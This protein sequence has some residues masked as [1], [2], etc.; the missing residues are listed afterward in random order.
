MTFLRGKQNRL[1]Q[2]SSLSSH[3]NF[4][5]FLIHI[6]HFLM[7]WADVANFAVKLL[8]SSIWVQHHSHKV[9]DFEGG[10]PASQVVIMLLMIVAPIQPCSS[11]S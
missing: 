10:L 5:E 3:D 9:S 4:S 1:E 2:N 8:S 7:E 6:R 11:S